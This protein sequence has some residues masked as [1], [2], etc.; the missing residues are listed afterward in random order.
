[1]TLG[2]EA[3]GVVHALGSAVEGLTEGQRVAAAGITPCFQCDS[4][5]R[6]FSSQCQGRMLGGARF[7]NQRDG[8]LAQY[9]LV[10]NA[11]ANLAPI[12]DE[13]SDHQALY[14]TDML[15]TGFVAAEHAELQLGETV[16]IFAQG[17]VGLS[18]TIGCRL[19]GAGLIIAVESVPARQE[20]AR[21]F[22]ADIIVDY[23]QCD[24]VER[25]LELTDGQGVD[26]AIEALGAPTP[27]RQPSGSPSQEGASP[28][29]A[30]TARY[31]SH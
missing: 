30:T 23:S 20:L 3:V 14:A 16:A 7:T 19:L 10:N 13:L 22:G 15:S 31:E 25:I 8:T 27:G 2:H 18:A 28:T 4:C 9:F 12:P 1:M 11:E 24:P 17:A 5:Q 6:G 21:H 29:S 26:A